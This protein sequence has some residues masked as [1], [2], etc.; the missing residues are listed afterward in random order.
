[1]PAPRKWADWALPRAPTSEMATPASR[2]PTGPRPSTR[3]DDIFIR[4]LGRGPVGGLEAGVAI[5]D[6]GA[7]GNAQSAHLRGAGIG[8]VVSVQIGS[9]QH[10]IFVRPGHHLLENRIGNAV[11]DHEL[12][13][14]RALAMGGVNRLQ[15]CPHLS[16]DR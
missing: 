14:P 6:V 12:L 9:G 1:M 16:V 10:R 5:S 7:R 3:I 13:F 11:V 4:V 2:P 15:N 8:N